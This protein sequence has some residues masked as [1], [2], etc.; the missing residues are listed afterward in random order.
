[1]LK[2]F[3]YLSCFLFALMIVHVLY[4][5][6]TEHK[7]MENA[8]AFIKKYGPAYVQLLEGEFNNTIIKMGAA[9]LIYIVW[10]LFF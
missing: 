4:E 5:M 9:G 1:M 10:Y 6:I 3:F 8:K 2:Y 7:R